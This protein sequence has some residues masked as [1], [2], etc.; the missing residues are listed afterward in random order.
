MRQTLYWLETVDLREQLCRGLIRQAA[1]RQGADISRAC[2]TPSRDP[3]CISFDQ[4]AIQIHKIE[5]VT[6]SQRKAETVRS[7]SRIWCV[8]VCMCVWER[9]REGERKKERE[10]VCVCERERERERAVAV[11][12]HGRLLLFVV[13]HKH[14]RITP[15]PYY[16]HR[17]IAS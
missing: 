14:V 7:E 11:L 6:A 1:Q 5:S 2:E 12:V 15:Y 17:I 8:C 4:A 16:K 9:E 10:R 13:L 3:V